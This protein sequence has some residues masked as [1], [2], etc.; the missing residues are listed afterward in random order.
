MGALSMNVDNIKEEYLPYYY[1]MHTI[2]GVG[3]K[4]IAKF[5]NIW[6]NPIAFYEAG[7]T[8]WKEMLSEKWAE[9]IFSHKK[10][11][12]IE[13]N[14]EKLQTEKIEIIPKYYHLYPKQ[15][16]QIYDPP[17]ILYAKGNR[18]E[19]S[20]PSVAIIGARL[21]SPYG[22]YMAKDLGSALAF[23]GITVVSGMARG[24]D[25]IAQQAALDTGGYSIGILGCGV[26]VCYP[27][28]NQKLYY[29]LI[30]R[31]CLLSELPPNT[32]PKAG[33]F[34]LRNRIISGLSD[35]V[36]VIEAR[37]KSGTVIT[38][39]QALEQGREVYALP[40]RVTDE[41]SM[42][43]NKLIKQGA[44]ILLNSQEFLQ[45]IYGII[46]VKDK[47]EGISAKN[48]KIDSFEEKVISCLDIQ[49]LSLDEILERLQ[50]MSFASE[51]S[52]S[53]LME[54]LLQLVAKGLVIEEENYYRKRML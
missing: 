31:G 37:E 20:H 45:D 46:T 16:L 4:R 7:S 11:W 26:N 1:W 27:K 21:C 15:L 33:F 48:G 3:N 25:G 10:D 36:A 39:D 24:V 12:N 43:C 34:P 38:V 42:G 18:I 19:L 9:V 49:L 22:A 47:N 8:G 5:L 53:K 29:D 44:G 23:A 32:V 30:N 40:G 17:E 28:D 35:V 51:I 6:Q 13:K 2:P 52:Y 54:C 50:K 41:L 14:W